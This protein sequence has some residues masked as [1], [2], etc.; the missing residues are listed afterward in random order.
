MGDRVLKRLSGDQIVELKPVDEATKVACLDRL[1]IPRGGLYQT[2]RG[3]Y[4][5]MPELA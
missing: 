1:L 3:N 4:C 2:P 5:D